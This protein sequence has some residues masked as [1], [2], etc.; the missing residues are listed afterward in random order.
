MSNEEPEV[1]K[2]SDLSM[3]FAVEI[4]K[5]LLPLICRMNGNIQNVHTLAI[6]H[7]CGSLYRAILGNKFNPERELGLLEASQVFAKAFY[8]GTQELEFAE[9]VAKAIDKE[10]GPRPWDGTRP[11]Q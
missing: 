11:G 5:I 8:D 10:F 4:A 3:Q 1:I 9:A 6:G 7:A 2:L